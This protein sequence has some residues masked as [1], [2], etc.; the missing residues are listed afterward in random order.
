[1][2][3]SDS[4]DRAPSLEDAMSREATAVSHSP[5]AARRRWVV[6][7]G[8]ATYIVIAVVVFLPASPWNSTRLPSTIIGGYGYGDPAQ[9]TWFLAWVPYALAHGLSLFHSN[10]I[11]YPS[12]VN[13][14]NGTPATLLALLASPVTATL[15][16]VAAFNVLLRLAYATSASSMFLVLRSWCRTPAAFIGGLFYAFCPYMVTQGQTHLNLTFVPL[17]PLIV[18]LVYRIITGRSRNIARD[19]VWLGVVAAAQV[20]IEPELLV[21]VAVVLGVGVVVHLVLHRNAFAPRI[22]ALARTGA[23]SALVFVVLAGPLLWEI[24]AGPGHLTGPPLPVQ[25]LQAY[26]ADL[27]SPVVPTINQFID[28]KSIGVFAVTLVHANLT[29]NVGY[30]GVPLILLLGLIATKYR[31]DR[32]IIG[33]TA[34]AV[35]AFVLSLG[36]ILKVDGHATGLPLPEAVLEHLPHFDSLVPARFGFVVTLFATIALSVGGERLVLELRRVAP[37]LRASAIQVVEALLLVTAA[38]FVVPQIPFETKAPSW[39][40]DTLSVLRA[41]PNNAVVLSYPLITYYDTAA[42]SW[43]AASKMRFRLIGGY[44]TVQGADDVGT[45][46]PPL[47][48]VPFVQEFL[49]QAQESASCYYPPPN[50]RENPRLA[51]CSFIRTYRVRALVYWRIGA[52]PGE[53]RRLFDEVAGAPASRTRNGAIQV[54]VIRRDSSC[55]RVAGSS[56]PTTT[57]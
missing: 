33:S 43:Q 34:L 26:R 45:A 17:P 40:T 47:S 18:W 15:G 51:L 10:F 4:D 36:P 57:F 55:A 5:G 2:T 13:L 56:K 41:I 24:V 6:V 12:G 42:M 48:K 9:M 19:G 11:D 20:Y 25:S 3:H 46:C 28:P 37:T 53:V 1:M 7:L 21:L 52:H 8:L 31:R 14:A 44:A 39:P 22:V 49:H 23:L 54:W 16:P 30:L 38:A 29:E 35:V 50:R 27:L 32:L